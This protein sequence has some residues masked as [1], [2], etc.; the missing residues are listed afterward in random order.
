[1]LDANGQLIGWHQRLVGQS[2]MMGT[3]MA[4][5]MVKDGI[6]GSSVEG[7]ANLAYAVPHLRVELHTP[8]D[9]GVPVQWWRSVGHTH[10]AFSTESL[11][12]EAAVAAGRDPVAFRRA[13]LADKPHHL[14]VLDLA[15]EKA[16]WDKPL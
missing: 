8:E 1:A 7:A 14:G 9:I 13:L 10:T 6:D 16:G 3:A 15:V 12:D 4:Q 11:V 5:Y 2:I